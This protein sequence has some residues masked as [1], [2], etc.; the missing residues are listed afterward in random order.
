MDCKALAASIH[1]EKRLGTLAVISETE[2]DILT[3]DVNEDRHIPY[4]LVPPTCDWLK[5]RILWGSSITGDPDA[6]AD[7]I[8]ET[9]LRID[10]DMLTCLNHICIISKAE[11]VELLCA[12]MDADTEE[13]PE[14]I[15]F[16]E[17][18]ILGCKWHI[19][20]SIIIN[21][22]AIEQAAQELVFS[23]PDYLYLDDEMKIAFWTT[24]LHEIRHLGL[25]CN[26]FLPED[27]Y[28]VSLRDEASVEA[29]A[30]EQYEMF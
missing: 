26:P 30:I 5:L 28:Q 18:T 16:E 19:Q 11:D 8:A 9:L 3:D 14:C 22:A 10:S 2:E 24:L 23:D 17:P 27:K 21:T 6:F 15:D 7:A 1:E 29:W 4:H 25:E 20:N 12:A 13:F